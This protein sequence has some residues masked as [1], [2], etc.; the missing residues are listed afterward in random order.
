M[1]LGADLERHDE[2]LVIGRWFG[3]APVTFDAGCFKVVVAGLR[4]ADDLL[5]L[6]SSDVDRDSRHSCYFDAVGYAKL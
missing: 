1:R 2:G 3:Y 5:P 4:Q 6:I